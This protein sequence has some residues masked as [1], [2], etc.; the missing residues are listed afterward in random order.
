MSLSNR[1]SLRKLMLSAALASAFVVTA[2]AVQAQTINAVMHS[3]VRVLDPI[4]TTAHITRN[5]GYMIYD[6]LLATDAKNEI[7]P[8][9]VEKWEASADGKSYT[10]T[11]RPGLKWH[12]GTPVTAEDCVASIK[13]WAEQ[14][15]MGQMM[16]GQ[17]SEMKVIDANSFVMVFKEATDIAVR[18]L[19]KPS[20]IAPF[21]MP[22]RIAETPSTQPIKEFIGSGPFK[23]VAAEFKPGLQVVYEKNTDYVPRKEPASGLAGGKV[24]NV[25]RVKWVAMPDAMTSVNAL[26][27][28]EI[29]Y[30]EQMPYDLLPLVENNPDIVLD[31]FDPQGYQTV[32][33]M[34]FLNPPFD[35]KKV[36]QAAMYAVGQEDV[37]QALVGNPKYFKTCAALFGCGL[38]YESQAGAEVTVK[39]NIAR[40]KELLKEAGYKGEPVVILQPTDAA[41]VKTQPVVIG[42][43]LRAA[44][45]NVQMQAMDWQTLVTRRASQA[46][47]AD[48]G[49]NIF[50][51]NN[52]MAEALDPLRAFGVAANGKQAWFGW[53]D[54][55]QIEVLR[56]QFALTTDLAEQKKLANDIQALVVEEGVLLPMGQYYVPAAIRKTLSKPVEAPVPVFWN[57]KKT[58]K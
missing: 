44:G 11:L 23:M 1:F 52:V 4:M 53:P 5:H 33:R 6:T 49:W 27:N 58:G 38:P 47:L 26:I 8:Q 48:G 28:G 9:M 34:N 29:D 24:V 19:A 14:D 50:A 21:M 7:Q 37:L 45:F 22:K 2:P 15:K 43:A 39:P 51:T 41:S 18:A 13:R 20:G 10:F 31:V 12:D 3:S 25:D 42:Q 57:M 46:S 40:A 32:M 56:K 16:T 35:N 54:V 36:R 55:P 17:M 30:L